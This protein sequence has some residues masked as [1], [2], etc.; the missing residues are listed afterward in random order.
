[1]ENASLKNRLVEKT[2]ELNRTLSEV[3]ELMDA[4]GQ[5]DK[6]KGVLGGTYIRH[7]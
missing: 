2:L 3:L 6:L 7:G 1:V 5:A 4:G